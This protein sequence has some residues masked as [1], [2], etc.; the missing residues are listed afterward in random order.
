ME[1]Q[2]RGLSLWQGEISV[3]PLNGGLTNHNFLVRHRGQAY[4]ARYCTD[5]RYIGIDRINER[6]CQENAARA[7]VSPEV[8]YCDDAFLVSR[9][10]PGRTLTKSDLLDAKLLRR[11]GRMLRQ[12]H[13][14]RDHLTGELL[15]FCPFQAIRTYVETARRLHAPL[16]PDIEALCGQMHRLARRMPPF[17][18]VLCHNDLL[19]ANV[20]DDGSKLWLVD[21][22]YGG[23]GNPLF[24]L[25][26]VAANCRLPETLEVELLGA[27]FGE[28]AE[29][30][31][32]QLRILKAASL[33][34]EALWSLIQSVKSRLDFDYLAYADENMQAFR[35]VVKTVL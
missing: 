3:T 2:L 13:A 17:H 34:R 14:F 10:L 11:L 19:P 9:F 31:L 24:D 16:P 12:L 18:P 21:W 15:Y 7:G 33:L 23:V 20:V 22:E 28:P 32:Q 8:I 25:A 35:E 27:Y 26:G 30:K 1:Q 4:V 6:L 29:G 5:L